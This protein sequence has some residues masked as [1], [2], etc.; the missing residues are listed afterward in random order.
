VVPSEGPPAAEELV[1]GFEPEDE[2]PIVFLRLR[3]ASRKGTRVFSVAP[4]TSRGL[5]KVGGTLI[6]AVPGAETAVNS[7]SKPASSPSK[8]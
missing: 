3:K 2:S 7:R 5:S 4:F 8:P 1:A 6:Q